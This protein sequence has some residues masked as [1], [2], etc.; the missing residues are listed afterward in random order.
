MNKHLK[1]FVSIAM[2]STMVFGLVS[3]ASAKTV[4]LQPSGYKLEVGDNAPTQSGNSYHY[5][6][7][8]QLFTYDD[9]ADLKAYPEAKDAVNWWLSSGVTN[10][11]KTF[12][13]FGADDSFYRYDL[14]FF[15]YRYYSIANDDGMW[16]YDDVPINQM[17]STIGLKFND[18][19]T[20]TRWSGIMGGIGARTEANPDP[21]TGLTGENCFDPFGSVTPEALLTTLFRL[22]NYKDG[23]VGNGHPDIMG[24]TTMQVNAHFGYTLETLSAEEANEVLGGAKV[25]AWAKPYVAAMVKKGLYKVGEGEDLTAAMK[26]VDVIE[27]LYN[28]CKG[29]G[30]RHHMTESYITATDETKVYDKDETVK[31]AKWLLG[32]E[33]EAKAL[34]SIIIKNG[35]KITLEKADI[36]Y[37]QMKSAIPYP[38]AYRWGHC[39]GI[40]AYGEGT[41]VT[42]KDSN[43]TV[44]KDSKFAHQAVT[45]VEIETGATVHMINT[46]TTG[47]TSGLLCYDGTL[48]YEDC[49]LVSSGRV[50]SSDFFSG[51]TIYNNTTVKTANEDGSPAGGFMDEAA[52]TYV[53]GSK[54][55]QAGTGNQTGISTFYAYDSKLTMSATSCTNNT[56]MLSDVTSTILEKCDV[57]YT[58]A[59]ANV[60]REGKLVIK[61]I[62]C[63]EIKLGDLKDGEYDISVTGT[64]YGSASAVRV[65]LDGS[66]FS[67]ALKVYVANGC[68][69][70]IIYT[71]AKPVVEQDTSATKVVKCYANTEVKAEENTTNTGALTFTAA[72]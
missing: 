62:D 70:E 20:N 14:A 24:D 37:G 67:R 65:Y 27:T 4:T 50:T 18:A 39:A 8:S 28:I 1:R 51:V 56:S 2:A 52:S 10:G 11:G 31:D 19:V 55:F 33:T 45:G 72:K 5:G 29:T 30:G 23:T 59:V 54:D 42:I 58:G 61:Y 60:V 71:G 57:T 38:L 25:S 12:T 41:Y 47:D 43:L 13:E 3:T 66:T 64:E 36:T 53:V 63:G 16:F 32:G 46:T 69:L 44:T 49:S 7:N 6:G 9:F 26:K 35:A 68:S 17:G 40:L 22:I 21:V 15:L 48:I 34:N